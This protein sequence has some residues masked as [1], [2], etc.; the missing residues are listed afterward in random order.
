MITVRQV[1][2]SWFD[3]LAVETAGRYDLLRKSG[4]WAAST[5]PRGH[6]HTDLIRLV[7]LFGPP[8]RTTFPSIRPVRDMALYL[9]SGGALALASCREYRE[10]MMHSPGAVDALAKWTNLNGR[11]GLPERIMG[12][13]LV[14]TPD[15]D[16]DE[17]LTCF[18]R[19]A[20]RTPG[21][22]DRTPLHA[23]SDYLQERD[24]PAGERI[25]E[26]LAG[27]QPDTAMVPALLRFFDVTPTEES[28]DPT[29]NAVPDPGSAPDPNR[30]PYDWG[31]ITT[32]GVPGG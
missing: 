11:W 32:A 15:A 13:R 10:Y 28:S 8:S 20:C 6:V 25:A 14:V 23:A 17:P 30:G 1:A 24:D 2:C 3:W 9:T 21:E 16:W 12:V 22:I 27:P 19:D 4:D 7:R 18:L 26:L 29:R 31:G 5:P